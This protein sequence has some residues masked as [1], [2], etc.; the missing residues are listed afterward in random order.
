[1]S[2]FLEI[3]AEDRTFDIIAR[4]ADNPN[5]LNEGHILKIFPFLQ[6]KLP[7]KLNTTRLDV[8]LFHVSVCFPSV[9]S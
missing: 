6:T 1:M 9:L 2:L 4:I 3:S 8:D 5:I 7:N